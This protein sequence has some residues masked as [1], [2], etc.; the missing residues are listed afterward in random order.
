MGV[1]QF[2][3]EDYDVDHNIG[4]VN[5]H[6]YNRG[7]RSH[8]WDYNNSM[9][10]QSHYQH[11]PYYQQ[12][13]QQKY[14]E[15]QNEHPSYTNSGSYYSHHD[16]SYHQ[17]NHN[18][19]NYYDRLIKEREEKEKKELQDRIDSIGHEIVFSH[20]PSNEFLDMLTMENNEVK[21]FVPLFITDYNESD[22][23]KIEMDM[24]KSTDRKITF[25]VD[26]EPKYLDEYDDLLNQMKEELTQFTNDENKYKYVKKDNNT[27]LMNKLMGVNSEWVNTDEEMS[28]EVVPVIKTSELPLGYSSVDVNESEYEIIEKSVTFDDNV[29]EH[30]YEPDDCSDNEYSLI[31]NVFPFNVLF[32]C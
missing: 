32:G 8:I 14:Q 3:D 4:L 30:E 11:Q 9:P 19:Y 23:S 31:P 12:K 15:E 1:Y 21:E 27:D 13:Y 24:T 18:G 2:F 17:A 20:I 26:V 10:Y 5:K 29:I 28:D 16:H 22:D 25:D 7:I 6:R